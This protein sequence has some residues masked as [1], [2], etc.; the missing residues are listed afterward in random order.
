[1]TIRSSTAVVIMLLRFIVASVFY[2]TS[3]SPVPMSPSAIYI[4]S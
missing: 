3:R 4:L 2:C 1:M